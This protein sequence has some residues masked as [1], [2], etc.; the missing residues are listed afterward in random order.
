[1][2]CLDNWICKQRV[3]V[4]GSGRIDVRIPVEVRVEER[5]SV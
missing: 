3:E 2:L 4:Q 1:M 5:A